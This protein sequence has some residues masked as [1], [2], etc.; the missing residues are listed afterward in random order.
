MKFGV[1]LFPLDEEE[2]QL[3]TDKQIPGI[4]GHQLV[5]PS[6]WQELVVKSGCPIE[7][8]WS[9][10]SFGPSKMLNLPEE[11]LSC[12]S[13]RWILF[14]PDERWVNHR[15]NKFAPSAA[16]QPWEGKEMIGKIID[17]GLKNLT[18]QNA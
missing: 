4:S 2:L 10:L 3:P 11:R 6:L 16:N 1:Y 5:L 12:E 18:I 8:L 13:N 17:C 7:K 9:T 14:N 15:L